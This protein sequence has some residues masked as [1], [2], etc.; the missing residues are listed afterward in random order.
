MSAG[1]QTER[2]KECW[3]HDIIKKK[4]LRKKN[5]CFILTWKYF[6]GFYVQS[7]TETF[8]KNSC[9]LYPLGRSCSKA[10]QSSF[11]CCYMPVWSPD[12]YKMYIVLVEWQIYICGKKRTNLCFVCSVPSTWYFTSEDKWQSVCNVRKQTLASTNLRHSDLCNSANYI[13]FISFIGY[14]V[15][16]NYTF[17]LRVVRKMAAW[18]S[19]TSIFRMNRKKKKTRI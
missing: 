16:K 5:V 18:N 10:L 3:C 8:L 2:K 19:Y 6:W 11:L 1:L 15:R 4:T 7:L 12:V 13:C 17:S 14:T 9:N